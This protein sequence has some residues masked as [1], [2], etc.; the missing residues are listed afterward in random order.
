M[1]Q[2]RP[3]GPALLVCGI[4]ARDQ[5]AADR[6]EAALARAFGP[7]ADRSD[8]IPFGFTDYYR[9]ELGDRPVRCW[10]AFRDAAD[11]SR[12]AEA[13]LRTNAIEQEMA[14]GRGL[15]TANLD[16]GILTLH[17]LVLASTKDYD[18]R[19]LLRDGIY[20]ELTLRFRSG[21]FEP[22]PW[23]YADYRTEA[24]LGFLARCRV[25]LAGLPAAAP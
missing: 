20:A 22:L 7:V 6:A 3:A 4:I 17:N 19:V 2:P 18:H 13:K 21:R 24:C 8:R 15:R 1:G 10:V 16:P 25:R 23:T 9:E 11:Q 5:D 12:L 14:D